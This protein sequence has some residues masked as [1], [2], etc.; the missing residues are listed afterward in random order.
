MPW[1]EPGGLAGRHGA[2]RSFSDTSYD[3]NEEGVPQSIANPLL[4]SIE[5]YEG[6]SEAITG[7]SKVIRR[8][9]RIA[10]EPWSPSSRSYT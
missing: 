8:P 9:E 1:Y 5:A 2:V 10:I 4:S 6:P 3:C 7:V